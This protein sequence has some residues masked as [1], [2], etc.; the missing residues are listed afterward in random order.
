MRLLLRASALAAW[1]VIGSAVAG[2]VLLVLAW[3]S[4]DESRRFLEDAW[5]VPAEVVA[6]EP[7]G[8]DLSRPV[9]IVRFRTMQGDI[10]NLP[11]PETDVSPGETVNLLYDG[12]DPEKIRVNNYWSLWLEAWAL[13]CAGALLAVIPA[14][15]W[16]RERFRS[17][18]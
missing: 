5:P 4:T 14:A 10:L 16:L 18:R 15:A 13:G 6:L 2:L 11:L 1:S 9:P 7:R 12:K 17:A 8:D 3:R